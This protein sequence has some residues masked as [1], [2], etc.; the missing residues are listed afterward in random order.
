[1]L[2]GDGADVLT[3]GAGSDKLDGGVGDDSFYFALGDGVDRVMDQSGASTIKFGPGISLQDLSANRQTIDGEGYI[4]LA[5]SAGDAVLIK[6]G[7]VLT[8]AAFRFADGTTLSVDEVYAEALTEARILPPFTAGNDTIYGYAGDDVLQGGGG[9][10]RLLG[11]MGSDTLD[12]GANDDWLEAA[13]E[14]I[15]M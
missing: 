9:V 12:G 6:D 11:G 13:P 4:R 5:Y 15:P 8:G 1:M 7:V 10:E 3:G 2:G 14:T